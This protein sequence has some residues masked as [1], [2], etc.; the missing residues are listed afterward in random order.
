MTEGLF[1]LD[2][3]QSRTEGEDMQPRPF[4]LRFEIV[5]ISE[6]VEDAIAGSFDCLIASHAG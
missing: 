1:P 6:D 2:N 5:P 3:S 4:E